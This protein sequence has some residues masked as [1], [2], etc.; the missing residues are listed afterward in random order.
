LPAGRFVYS[1]LPE[2]LKADHSL[3]N[4]FRKNWYPIL[5]EG[6]N[7]KVMLLFRYSRIIPF[8]KNSSL[9]F[10]DTGISITE[11]AFTVIFIRD[12]TGSDPS[13]DCGEKTAL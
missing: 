3:S 13:P 11:S 6:V 9:S 7:V 12:V 2:Y 10:S 8:L 1:F 4:P 5:S